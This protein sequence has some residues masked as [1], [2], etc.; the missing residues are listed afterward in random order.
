MKLGDFAVQIQGGR[1]RY[2][3]YVEMAHST[4]YKILLSNDS[5]LDCDAAVEIDGKEVGIW[6]VY[7]GKNI[8]IERPVHDTG[9]FTFYK[10]DSSEAGKIG[11]VGNDKLGLISVLFKPEKPP[12]SAADNKDDF[13]SFDFDDFACDS[14]SAGGT[15]LSGKSEQKF[16]DVQSLDY[17]E[18]SFVQI[19]LRLVCN[20]DEPRPLMPLSTPIPPSLY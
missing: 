6:R 1:E 2:T 11:L 20:D 15:G 10:L 4:K 3:G 14:Y 8:R 5:E 17:N 13:E 7:S 18:A 19:H 9:Q 16:I 12:V